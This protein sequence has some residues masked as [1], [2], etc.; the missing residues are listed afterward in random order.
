M[1]QK[2]VTLFNASG[3]KAIVNAADVKKFEAMGFSR[4]DE[5]GGGEVPERKRRKGKV[6]DSEESVKGDG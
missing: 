1:M 2:T 3:Y 4:R 5:P 6:S